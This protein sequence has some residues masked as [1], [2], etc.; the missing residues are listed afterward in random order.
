MTYTTPRVMGMVSADWL[1]GFSHRFASVHEG[2]GELEA[3]L[4]LGTIRVGGL[5]AW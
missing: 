5:R 2:V 3:A 4:A 1:M